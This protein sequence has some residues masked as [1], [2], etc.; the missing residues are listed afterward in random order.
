MLQQQTICAQSWGSCQRLRPF[1]VQGCSGLPAAVPSKRPYT[2]GPYAVYITAATCW[3]HTCSTTC[4]PC[5]VDFRQTSYFS[6][7]D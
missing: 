7:A 5:S 3:L 6:A 1:R 4:C 2:P